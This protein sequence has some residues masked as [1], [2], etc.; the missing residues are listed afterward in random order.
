M[1]A[2]AHQEDTAHVSTGENWT[3]YVRRVTHG[4]PRKDIA[5]AADIH[6]SG[7]G[8]WLKGTSRPSVEKVISFAHGLRQNPVDALVA[9]GYLEPSDVPGS[10]EIVRSTSELSDEELIEELRTRLIV[11]KEQQPWLGGLTGFGQQPGVDRDENPGKG[12]QLRGR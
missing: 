6:V 2:L 12:E 9:A 7:V 10:V 5:D 1:N 11:A 4:Q 3:A 8:R